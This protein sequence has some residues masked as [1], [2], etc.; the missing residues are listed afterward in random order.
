MAGVMGLISS[1]IFYINVRDDQLGTP[2]LMVGDIA[3][4]IFITRLPL[5]YLRFRRRARR[6][7][8]GWSPRLDLF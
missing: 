2:T 6:Q 8:T 1:V 4:A 7:G 3:D 5:R